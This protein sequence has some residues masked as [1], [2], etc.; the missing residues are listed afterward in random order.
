[1]VAARLVDE[2]LDIRQK[3]RKQ[4]HE[5]GGGTT[6][7]K[8]NR[9]ALA[10]VLSRRRWDA[11]STVYTEPTRADDELLAAARVALSRL[12]QGKRYPVPERWQDKL[13]FWRR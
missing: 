10:R 12:V 1:M 2:D 6:I 13:L 5:A 7:W 11:V 9:V 4:G 8:E 3:T